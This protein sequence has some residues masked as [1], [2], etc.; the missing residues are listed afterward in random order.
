M[1]NKSPLPEKPPGDHYSVPTE[2]PAGLIPIGDELSR[3]EETARFSAQGQFEAAKSWQRCNFIIGVPASVFGL[4]SGGAAFTEAFPVWVVGGGALIGAA[5]AGIMTVMGAER[6]ATRAKTCANTFHDIQDEARRLL[7]INLASMDPDKAHAALTAVCDR[8]SETRHAADA[9]A[10]RFY[11]QAK[12]N[13]TAGGQ[14]FAI[15]AA[16]AAAARTA[17]PPPGRAAL[18]APTP[19]QPPDTPTDPAQPHAAD[20]L[21]YVGEWHTHPRLAPPS[22]VDHH[23]MRTMAR[24]NRQSVALIVAALR[25]DHRSVDLHALISEPRQPRDRVTGRH[26]VAVVS[27]E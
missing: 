11:N 1:T 13:I 3:L 22:P 20:A 27:V 26:T 14:Q 17:P 23:A 2:V 16:K 19:T 10:R 4:F 18:P 21:G 7:L 25:D 6:R 24:R 8:Y 5:L 9:P 12:K 15:D